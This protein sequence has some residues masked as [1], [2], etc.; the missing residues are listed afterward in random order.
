MEAPHA[1]VASEG[2]M[3]VI[4]FHNDGTGTD[5]IGNYN[6]VIFLNRTPIWEGRVEGH[7][8]R[9]GWKALLKDLVADLE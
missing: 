9:K 7:D 1:P 2:L 4:T 6:I 3:L 5:E 8:R